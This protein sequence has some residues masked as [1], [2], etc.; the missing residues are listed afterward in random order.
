M[1]KLHAI[2]SPGHILH[3]HC[4]YD[5][6]TAATLCECVRVPHPIPPSSLIK[7]LIMLQYPIF[8]LTAL[9][10]LYSPSLT[11]ECYS[12]PTPLPDHHDCSVLIQAIFHLSRLPGQSETKEWGRNLTTGPHA[13][14]LPKTYWLDGPE[15]YN[16]AIRVDSVSQYATDYFKVEDLGLSGAGIVLACLDMLRQVGRDRPGVD[17][18]VVANLFWTGVPAALDMLNASDVQR[19][20]LPKTKNVLLSASV[21]TTS[22]SGNITEIGRGAFSVSTS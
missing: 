14:H 13:E 11:I 15:R 10:S 1:P 20:P 3:P 9:Y 7:V 12:P 8:L 4:V 6:T 18:L 5:Y 22:F 19:V 17:H 16:C 2:A 21:N